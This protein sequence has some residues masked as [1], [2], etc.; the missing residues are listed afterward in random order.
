MREQ[1]RDARKR[2]REVDLFQTGHE[3]CVLVSGLDVNRP[4]DLAVDRID[5]VAR[6]V[7]QTGPTVDESDRLALFRPLD[8]RFEGIMFFVDRHGVHRD[9][10][11]GT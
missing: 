9:R 2:E 5:G 6:D 1:T 10:P 4:V 3:P 11:T 8:T 7:C